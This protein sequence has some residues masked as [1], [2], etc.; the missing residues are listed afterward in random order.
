E[1][2]TSLQLRSPESR[3]QQD[4]QRSRSFGEQHSPPS[5]STQRMSAP[6][7]EIADQIASIAASISDVDSRSSRRLRELATALTTETGRQRWS[8]VDLSRAFN[9]DRLAH[10][11]AVRHEGGY[12]PNSVEVADKIRNVLVLVPILLTWA[13]LGEAAAA[14]ERYLAENPD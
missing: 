3:R 12:A 10:T 4:D 6:A 1:R 5:Q 7:P 8:D 11:Y 9:S 13:A 14:Y 2:M